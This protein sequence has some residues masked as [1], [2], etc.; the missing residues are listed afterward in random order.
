[1][2]VRGFLRVK[3]CTSCIEG[4]KYLSI[5]RALDFSLKSLQILTREI[6]MTFAALSLTVV[7]LSKG[8]APD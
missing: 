7:W 1:M 2:H 8:L 6:C 3:I 4:L 5:S